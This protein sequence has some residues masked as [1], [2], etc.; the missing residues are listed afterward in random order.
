MPHRDSIAQA[1][2][3]YITA[4]QP[5]L[6]GPRRAVAEQDELEET[7]QQADPAIEVSVDDPTTAPAKVPVW[8]RL[9][10]TRR[11]VVAVLILIGAGVL[12]ALAVIT[13]SSATPV[14]IEVNTPVSTVPT[15]SASPTATEASTMKIHVLGEVNRP[16][17]VTVPE[18]AIV[19][20]AV[21]AAGGFTEDADPAHLNLAAPLSAGQQII[22]GS[23]SEPQGEIRGGGSEAV[24]GT[25]EG[26]I[27]LNTATT[28]QLQELPGVGP[29]LAAAILDWRERNGGFSAVA[30][31]Q[32]VSGIGPKSFEKLAPLVTV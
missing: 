14:T 31:L 10:L 29:V 28:D 26:L 32:E 22:V 27:N 6:A 21:E 19:Q 23:R 11:H 8:Q 16:G 7:L 18:A 4:G 15:P 3:A 20:E 2:L 17:V 25:G 24:G 9:A 5:R 13:T 30:D 1:R 12:V